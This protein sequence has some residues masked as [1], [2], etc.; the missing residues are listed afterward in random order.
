L[1]PD[2]ELQTYY[3]A[4]AGEYDDVYL[5]RERQPE[6]RWLES[7]VSSAFAGEQVLEIACGTG[8]WTRF[9]ARSAAS[10]LASDLNPEPLVL[11]RDRDYGSTD[12]RFA[13]ADAYTLRGVPNGHTAAFH[14]FWW[15]HVPLERTDRFLEALHSRLVPEAHVVMID[16]VYAAGSS[17]PL[18]RTDE[19][20]NTYQIRELADGS[21]REILKNYPSRSG[22]VAALTHHATDV[23]VEFG[24]YYWIAEYQ[25]R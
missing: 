3:A 9:L 14:A 18:A 8:H 4:R 22:L 24:R 25:T 19:R 17:T 2:A 16:N 5:K 11:A 6:L 13:I 23:S 12:V 15:S 21:R 20:G 1:N 10:V 7:H